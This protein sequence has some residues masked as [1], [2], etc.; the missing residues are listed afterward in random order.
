MVLAPYPQ[1]SSFYEV[2][3]PRQGLESGERVLVVEDDRDLEPV[4]R[5]VLRTIDPALQLDWT[6][7]SPEAIRLL[8]RHSYR[9]VV[10]D[11]LLDEGSGTAVKR[12]MDFFRP[13]VPFAMI[14]GNQL[15]A[16]LVRSQGR[17]VPFL[18]KPFSWNQLRGFLEQLRCDD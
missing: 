9:W 13:R 11:Y 2:F 7:G 5:R 8:C 16:E 14:S 3:H 17:A 18:P 10:A 6:G 15:P 4:F 12:W 1:A